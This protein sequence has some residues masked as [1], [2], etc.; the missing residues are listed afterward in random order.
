M[1]EISNSYPANTRTRKCDV[2]E[3][4]VH[5]SLSP[6]GWSPIIKRDVDQG[7]VISPMLVALYF[8]VHPKD[9]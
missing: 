9:L 4:S 5:R 2:D 8:R 6:E 3:G 1:L 7:L